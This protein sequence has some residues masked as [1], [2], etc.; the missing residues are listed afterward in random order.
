MIGQALHRPGIEGTA[1]PDAAGNMSKYSAFFLLIWSPLN[2]IPQAKCYNSY[3]CFLL[4]TTPHK[5]ASDRLS[6]TSFQM[7]TSDLQQN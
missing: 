4:Q 1:K 6:N 2:Q 3:H 5:T 7:N